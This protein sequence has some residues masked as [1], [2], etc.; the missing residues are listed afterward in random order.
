[1]GMQGLTVTLTTTLAASALAGTTDYHG[2]L[3]V[4]VRNRGAG[5]IYLGGLTV[6]SGG[7]PMSSADTPLTFQVAEGEALYAMS[8]GGAAVIDVLRMNG[9]TGN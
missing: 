4:T 3:R 9:T 5:S 8:T 1:M 7:F 6:T 2:A